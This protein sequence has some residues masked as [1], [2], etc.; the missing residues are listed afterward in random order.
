MDIE[1]DINIKVTFIDSDWEIWPSTMEALPT[2]AMAK[3]H[4]VRSKSLPIPGIR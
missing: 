4:A 1:S 2:G 3:L